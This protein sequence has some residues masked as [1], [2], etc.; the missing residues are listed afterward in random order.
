MTLAVPMLTVCDELYARGYTSILI[1][2]SKTI[3]LMG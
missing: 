2:Y 1:V 3:V